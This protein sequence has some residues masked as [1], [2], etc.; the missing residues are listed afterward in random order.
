MSIVVKVIV[1]NITIISDNNIVIIIMIRIVFVINT[2]ITID[3]TI[4]IIIIIIL[5]N[6][7]LIRPDTSDVIDLN[8]IVIDH[9]GIMAQ[10]AS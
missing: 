5:I 2:V 4:I 3:I 7:I 1:N 10:F 8:N 6:V 9:I